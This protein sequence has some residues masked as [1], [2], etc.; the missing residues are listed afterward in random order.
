M[1]SGRLVKSVKKIGESLDVQFDFI[2]VLAVTET[3]STA[4][5][6]AS[7]FSGV[8]ATPANI[9]SGAAVIDGTQVDQKIVAGVAGT[10]YELLCT[11]TTSASRTHVQ[12]TLLA[13]G[14]NSL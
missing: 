14:P 10:I 8:D 9:V 1:T 6:T 13:I 3:L 5:V 12:S 4:T 11:V 7:V 2:S